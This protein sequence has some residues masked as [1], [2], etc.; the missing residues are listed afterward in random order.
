MTDVIFEETSSIGVRI[1]SSTEDLPAA[2][3][4]RRRD[5]LRPDQ[6]QSGPQ[7]RQAVNAQPEYEDCKAAAAKH[8]VALKMVRDMAVGEFLKG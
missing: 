4:N 1:S 5:Y 2:R 8:S 3:N 7:R 6:D